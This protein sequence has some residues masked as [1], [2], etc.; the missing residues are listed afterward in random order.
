MSRRADEESQWPN[1]P[2]SLPLPDD[3][4]LCVIGA[5]FGQLSSVELHEGFQQK[6][7]AQFHPRKPLRVNA[8]S[9][10]VVETRATALV[11][12][13]PAVSEWE[14]ISVSSYG[15]LRTVIDS[16][17]MHLV[18]CQLSCDGTHLL[19][20]VVLPHALGEG[21]EL[22][23]DVSGV[24]ALQ[25]RGSKLLGTRAMTG[26]AG[27][28]P[29]LGIAGKDQTKGR[30]ALPQAAPALGNA[31]AGDRRQPVRTT[32]EIGRHVSRVLNAQGGSDRAHNAPKAFARAVVVELFVDDHRIHSG[33]GGDEGG[34][35]HAALA[36]AGAAIERDEG[37][38]LLAAR[39]HSLKCSAGPGNT[40]RGARRRLWLARRPPVG[41]DAD[42]AADRIEGIERG[43]V[44]SIAQARRSPGGRIC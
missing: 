22:P 42:R 30:I 33:E 12:S 2:R 40:C 3:L 11:A 5:A 38:V 21:R 26:G 1:A 4:V 31:F 17:R 37:A 35:A 10:G 16:D 32:G 9:P 43:T 23:F 19:V 14:F 13:G 27:W 25:R 8:I 18:W 6:F 15:V 28:D 20:D 36:V 34:R 24:L 29:A 41:S 44:L 39:C 7:F